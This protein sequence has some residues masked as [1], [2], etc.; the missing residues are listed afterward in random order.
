[1]RDLN[2]LEIDSDGILQAGAGNTWGNV[3]TF[4]EGKGLSAIGGRQSDVGISGYLLGG[5]MPA[6]PNLHGLAADGVKNFEVRT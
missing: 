6:F 1:M 4:L 3:Y 2:T 5:G